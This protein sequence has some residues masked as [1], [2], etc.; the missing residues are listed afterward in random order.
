M[1]KGNLTSK[2]ILKQIA[3]REREKREDK[4]KRIIKSKIIIYGN[5]IFHVP[6]RNK[7]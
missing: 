7:S 4:D 3:R 2:E 5:V 6:Y 1:E